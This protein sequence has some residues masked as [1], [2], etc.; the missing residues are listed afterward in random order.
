MDQGMGKKYIN[1]QFTSSQ[2]RAKLSTPEDDPADDPE[3]PV[4]CSAGR[5]WYPIILGAGDD[6]DRR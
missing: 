1:P 5:V 2:L 3:L 4:S 6:S